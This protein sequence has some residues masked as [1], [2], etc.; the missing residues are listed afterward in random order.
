MRKINNK[1]K[2]AAV[3][4][5]GAMVVTGGGVAFAYWTQNGSGAGTAASGT[6]TA[7]T[8]VQTAT[9][10]NL[11]PGGQVALS[12]TFNNP[13][14]GSVRVGTVTATVGTL[15]SGC[16][17]AD[18]TIVGT[19]AVNAEI[20]AGSSVGSWSGITLKM[21]DTAVSQDACKA[22]TIPVTYSVS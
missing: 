14:S 10:S 11:Y 9:T 20:P 2:A 6:T 7:V 1:K 3:L 19:A 5:T 4:A 21:N 16:V 8:V 13:N 17:A 22:Q 18:F 12:G 15:P